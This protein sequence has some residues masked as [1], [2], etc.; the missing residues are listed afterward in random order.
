[1]KTL[2]VLFLIGIMSVF[3]VPHSFADEGY[4]HE[5]SIKKVRKT[6]R[7]ICLCMPMEKS[8]CQN[9]CATL[10]ITV[11]VNEKNELE[12]IEVKGDNENCVKCFTKKF[13][14]KPRKV[15]N[16]KSGCKYQVPLTLMLN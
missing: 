14:K 1:M 3:C 7:N 13:N 6:L 15:R 5:K 12:L 8:I 10:E 16:C 2:R 4:S 9:E 11:M